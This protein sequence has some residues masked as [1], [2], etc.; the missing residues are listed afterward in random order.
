MF[1]F[2]VQENDAHPKKFKTLKSCFN[3]SQHVDKAFSSRRALF[4]FLLLIVN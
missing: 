1:Q 3:T 4:N 2:S